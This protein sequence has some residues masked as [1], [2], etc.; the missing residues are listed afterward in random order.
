MELIK[1]KGLDLTLH[2]VKAHS[3]NIYNDMADEL[4]IQGLNIEPIN[5]DIKAHAINSLLL[6]I[7]NS[8]GIIDTNHRKWMKKLIQAR[9]FN[10]F[11]FNTNFNTLRNVFSNFD[12]NWEYTSL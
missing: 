10:N 7:W 9:I 2:K 12:I 6:P 3:N 1:N 8:M 4:A 11:I 5:L